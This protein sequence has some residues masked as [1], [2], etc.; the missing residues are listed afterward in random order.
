MFSLSSCREW[1]FEGNLWRQR[2]SASPATRLDVMNLQVSP[3]TRLDFM[4]LQVSPATR[5]NVMSLQV[6]RYAISS[7][8]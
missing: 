6:L 7:N 2:V 3:A 5:L 8:I 1:E 4:N